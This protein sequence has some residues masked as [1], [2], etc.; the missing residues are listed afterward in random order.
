MNTAPKDLDGT[1]KE[2]LG[3]QREELL[4]AADGLNVPERDGLPLPSTRSDGVVQSDVLVLGPGQPNDS[5][6]VGVEVSVVEGGNGLLQGAVL[7]QHA[8]AGGVTLDQGHGGLLDAAI[9]IYPSHLVGV[10]GDQLA[11]LDLAPVTAGK[12]WVGLAGG[13]RVVD[14]FLDGGLCE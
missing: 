12:L 2:G 5:Q 11:D 1:G 7:D 3:R 10:E 9:Q 8:V 6:Q 14:E 13:G 4:G